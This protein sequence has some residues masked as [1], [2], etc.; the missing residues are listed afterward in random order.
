MIA[1][2]LVQA[3]S[4]TGKTLVFALMALENLNAQL[5]KPQVMILAPTREIVMQI[6]STIRRLAPP[7]IHI[8]V[9]VG[10]NRSVAE[11][12]KEI[13]KGVQIIVC[14]TGRICQLVNQDL[15]STNHIRLF[16]LDEADKLMEKDFQKDIK[17]VPSIAFLILI[18][19]TIILEFCVIFLCCIF[20][21]VYHS[22]HKRE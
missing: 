1:D 18:H 7:V 14:T 17:F 11:D 2:I 13:R 4:G 9:F 22:C 20:Q 16:V 6:S 19:F 3:K 5:K 10:G 8:G 21:N 15:I 12:V